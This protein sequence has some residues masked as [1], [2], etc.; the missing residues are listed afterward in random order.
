MKLIIKGKSELRISRPMNPRTQN[1]RT[2]QA[3][4]L[5]DWLKANDR[6]LPK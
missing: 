1:S 3:G 6:I 4:F 2:N 5:I